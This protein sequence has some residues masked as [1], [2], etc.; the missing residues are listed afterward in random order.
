MRGLSKSDVTSKCLI[1]MNE[2]YNFSILIKIP[3]IFMAENGGDVIYGRSLRL[4]LM[5][6][7][8]LKAFLF[9]NCI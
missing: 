6:E 7:C 5:V 3:D 1:K 4:Y 9:D 8:V 2:F